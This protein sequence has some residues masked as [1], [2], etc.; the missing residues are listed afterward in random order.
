MSSADKPLPDIAEVVQRPLG[1]LGVRDGAALDGI[2]SQLQAAFDRE[3]MAL[4]ENPAD[5]GAADAFR[6]RW[7]GRKQGIIR[8]ITDTWLKSAPNELKRE[9]GQRANALR[10]LA[11]RLTEELVTSASVAVSATAP[12][13][14]AKT[15]IPSTDTDR[16]DIT[17]P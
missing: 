11:E 3:L 4:R 13:K 7:L 10:E 12:G 5:A 15:A 1:E 8:S 2:F 6:I 9:V 16:L 17:L 14:P